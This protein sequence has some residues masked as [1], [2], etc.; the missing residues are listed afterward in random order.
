MVFSSGMAAISAALRALTNAG[1]VLVVPA[2]GYYQVRRYAAE[3]LVPVG[4]KVIEA[5]SSQITDVAA[6]ADVVLAETP[7]N[8]GLDVVDLHAVGDGLPQPWRAPDRGQHD[9]HATR[10]AAAG[11]GR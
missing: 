5:A 3:Y 9:R 8:P 4:V 10:S 2:D 6:G 1:S 11:A 7:T